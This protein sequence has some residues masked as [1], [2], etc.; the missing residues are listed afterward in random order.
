ME[1]WE[2]SCDSDFGTI[3]S[4]IIR[5]PGDSKA[6]SLSQVPMINTCPY[7]HEEVVERQMQ[8]NLGL[9]LLQSPKGWC[10]ICYA[11]KIS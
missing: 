1:Q 11:Q 7:K 5:S 2:C 10:D 8:N 4:H 9:Y 6:P 3:S